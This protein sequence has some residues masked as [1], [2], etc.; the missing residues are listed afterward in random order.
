MTEQLIAVRTYERVDGRGK[1]VASVMQP[2]Y[3]EDIQAYRCEI[4]IEAPEGVTR[5]HASGADGMQALMYGL[6][7]LKAA[8]SAYPSRLCWMGN[9]DDL[10]LEAILLDPDEDER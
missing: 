10:A 3:A 5:H 2:R 4:V 9:C 6:V 7:I 1:V 8:L